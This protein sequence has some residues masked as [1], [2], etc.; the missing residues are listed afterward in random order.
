[1]EESFSDLIRRAKAG[2]EGARAALLARYQHL[3]LA[4]VRRRLAPALRRRFD[5][6]DVAQSVFED[7]LRDL[8]RFEERGEQAFRHWLYLKAENKI[9][10]AWRR[11]LGAD[12]RPREN[13]MGSTDPERAAPGPGPATE[14]GDIDDTSRLRDAVAALPDAQREV[15]A[16]RDDS[17][18]PF[19]AIA[20]KLGLPGADAARMRYARALLALRRNW[21]PR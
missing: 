13:T 21:E 18:L 14:A 6:M 4:A 17:G 8:P 9:R 12:G 19:A 15:I 5:S 11:R 20:K 7:V 3:V 16:L 1:L 2:E 10:D